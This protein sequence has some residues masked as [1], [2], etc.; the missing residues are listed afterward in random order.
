MAADEEGRYGVGNEADCRIERLPVS[1]EVGSEA[2]RCT[3]AARQ[4]VCENR[5][6]CVNGRSLAE[7]T[8]ALNR[9]RYR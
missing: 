1:L 6:G 5:H 8:T 7:P 3:S 2:H 4:G 9:R